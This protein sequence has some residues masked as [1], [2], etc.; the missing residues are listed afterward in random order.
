MFGKYDKTTFSS[1]RQ[2]HNIMVL[3]GNGFDIHL[4]LKSKLKEKEGKE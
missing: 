4:G 3:V 1:L 2:Q